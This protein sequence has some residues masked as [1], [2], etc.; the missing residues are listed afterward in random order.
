M[1]SWSRKATEHEAWLGAVEA[2]DHGALDVGHAISRRRVPRSRLGRTARC[3]DPRSVGSSAGYLPGRVVPRRAGWRPGGACVGW[4]EMSGDRGQT[5]QRGDP[6]VQRRAHAGRGARGS[7]RRSRAPRRGHRRG[8]PLDRSHRRDRARARRARGGGDERRLRRRR[9]QPRL[10]LGRGRCRRLPRRRR[11]AAAGLR[12]RRA[13]GGTRVPRRDRRLRPPLRAAH[14]LVVG[15][16][17]ADRD[18]LPG[19]GAAARRALRLLLLHARP[20]LARPAASTRATAA[21]TPSS[22]RTRSRAA[23][24]SSSTRATR[25][26]TTTT[27]TRSRSCAASSRAPPSPRRASA[28]CSARA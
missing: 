7:R 16:A 19:A 23:S 20:A 18:A 1:G 15:R 17:P 5:R 14:R 22:A 4:M 2:D 6:R 28:P 24:V 11:R 3:H 27:A 12:C 9:A 25:R 10:G 13:P 26:C 8:R 21:R